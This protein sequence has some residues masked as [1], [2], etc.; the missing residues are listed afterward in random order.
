MVYRVTEFSFHFV[1]GFYRGLPLSFF[2]WY[3]LGVLHFERRG[4]WAA[5]TTLALAKHLEEWVVG[6]EGF[7]H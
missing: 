5:F 7:H 4:E 3:I 6:Q 1:C 2:L